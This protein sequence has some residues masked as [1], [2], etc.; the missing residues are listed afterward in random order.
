MFITNT[1]FEQIKNTSIIYNKY[2]VDN[3]V[4][5][6]CNNNE[7]V[8]Y[9]D[10]PVVPCW[11]YTKKD[12]DFILTDNVSEIENFC[13]QHSIILSANK[14][15]ITYYGLHHKKGARTYKNCYQY[16]EDFKEIHLKP[17]GDY[18]VIPFGFKAFYKDPKDSYEQIQQLFKKYKNIIDN[19]VADGA[20]RPT[21]T[22][23]LDSRTLIGLYRDHL[24]EIDSYYLLGV[25]NDGLNKVHKGQEEMEI[26]KEVIHHLGQ[27]WT[28]VEDLNDK[29]TISSHL[30]ENQCK[31]NHF[32]TNNYE[33]YWVDK[34]VRHYMNTDNTIRWLIDPLYLELQ[35]PCFSFYKC[36]FAML[37]VP[38]LIEDIPLISLGH[39]YDQHGSY[40]FYYEN[41]EA[42]FKAEEVMKYWGKANC[43]NILK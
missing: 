6:D 7:I 41:Y 9:T 24:S 36:L 5:I 21:L 10:Y 38:D 33:S 42:R 34:V 39:N 25:K 29:V 3:K 37:L 26:A 17:N 23:G 15:A 30:N 27:N 12:N 8:I 35:I 1:N 19:I 13:Q 20:F 40:H 31:L 43:D 11:Y 16:I 2:V 28:R 18:T 14:M 4:N 22:G 32:V